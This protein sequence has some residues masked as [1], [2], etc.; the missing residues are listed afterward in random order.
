MPFYARFRQLAIPALIGTLLLIP[1][2]A[3]A[4]DSWSRQRSQAREQRIELQE[5]AEKDLLKRADQ[6]AQAI[7]ELIE[8]AESHRVP[9]QVHSIKQLISGLS[10]L[11]AQ[12][13]KELLAS[14]EQLPEPPEKVRSSATRRWTRT[15]E[16]GK[17]EALERTGNLLNGAIKLGI[18][19]LA[20]EFLQEIL[21]FDPD[22]RGIRSGLG[23]VKVNDRWLTPYAQRMAKKG[24]WWDR[25]IGWVVAKDI[26]RYET[27]AYFDLHGNR[28]TTLEA[29]NQLRSQ[30]GQEWVIKTRNVTLHT[31]LDLTDAIRVSNYLNGFYQNVFAAY[32]NF[33][34]TGK[35]DYKLV[36][37]L[38]EQQP[39]TV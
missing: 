31:T 22:N 36:L 9:G 15:L 7:E 24:Y 10:H 25:K 4:A 32:A 18:N 8:A 17:K 2:R 26:K 12:R 16:K 34:A 5:R 29:A 33:F 20:Y 1:S 14:L 13:A 23:Q 21:R 39:L 30:L 27:G 35:S 28:W 3:D 11:D 37:G 38:S 6:A 19:D